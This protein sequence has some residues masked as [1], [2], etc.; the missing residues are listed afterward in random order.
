MQWNT[1]LQISRQNITENTTAEIGNYISS[2]MALS[3]NIHIAVL[4]LLSMN[5][6]HLLSSQVLLG[7]VYISEL[8]KIG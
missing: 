7:N 3:R 2:P 8:R 4:D 6:F 1:F 5:W